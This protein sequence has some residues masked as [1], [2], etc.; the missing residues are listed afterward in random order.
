[1]AISFR[2]AFMVAVIMA[3][4]VVVT[5]MVVIM[6]LTAWNRRHNDTVGE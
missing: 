6:P 2:P 4:M 1:M 3:T 5:M